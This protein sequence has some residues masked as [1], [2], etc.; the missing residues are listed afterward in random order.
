MDW[1]RLIRTVTV[2][3]IQNMNITKVAMIYIDLDDD[4][5]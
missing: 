4:V 2:V 3:M 1:I 5:D